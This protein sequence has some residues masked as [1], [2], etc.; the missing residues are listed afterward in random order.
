MLLL[1]QSVALRTDFGD[2]RFVSLDLSLENLVL[3]QQLYLVS[4]I[5]AVRLVVTQQLALLFLHPGHLLTGILQ[6]EFV[7]KYVS[8]LFGLLPD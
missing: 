5:A 1:Y 7:I 2:L 3:L 6:K 4:Q 8:K